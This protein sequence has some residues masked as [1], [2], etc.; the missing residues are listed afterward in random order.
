MS[1]KPVVLAVV[2]DIHCNSALAAVPP[3]GVILDDGGTYKPSAA[4]SW[5]WDCWNDYWSLVEKTRKKLKARLWCVYNGDLFEGLAHHGTTQ[6]VSAHPE[7][8]A[9]LADRIFGVPRKLQPEKQF[10]VRGTEAHVGPSGATEEAFGRSIKAQPSPDGRWSWWHL[11]LNINGV[12]IDCQHH[13]STRGGVPWTA[14]QAAQ[15]MAFRIWSEHQLKGERPPDLVFRSHTHVWRDS[16]NAYP[17][18][19]IV[20]PP[21]QLKTAHAYK[22]AADSLA[23]I[24]GIVV[25]LPG[26]G[27]EIG[28]QL[29]KVALPQ[30]IVA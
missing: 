10:I 3:E 7:P 19:A 20:T 9:Y 4:Q 27:Y 6:I 29:Y 1:C 15:R 16:W 11:R 28:T 2:S 21:W 23:D 14:P 26:E 30:E 22:V 8:S 24:G 5:I 25:A 17:T 12:A 18:R 13:P